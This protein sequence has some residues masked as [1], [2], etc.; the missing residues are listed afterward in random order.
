MKSS[1]FCI[2]MRYNGGKYGL[3]LLVLKIMHKIGYACMVT[4]TN[5]IIEVCL[6]V[7]PRELG[8]WIKGDMYT[9]E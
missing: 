6:G 4:C 1:V 2:C 7:Q 8:W 5:W 9:W 3:L